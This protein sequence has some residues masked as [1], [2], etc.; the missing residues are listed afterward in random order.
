MHAKINYLCY[1]IIMNTHEL[2]YYIKNYIEN[3]KTQRAIMLT[4]PWGCGK[5]YYIKNN[6]CPFLIEN[7]LNYVVTS[8]YGIKST[9]DISRNIYLE[10]RSK[11]LIAKS[12][13]TNLL[14]ITGKTILKGITSFFGIDLS[15][16]EEDLQ[17]LY[18]S[19]NLSNYLLIFEDL[20]RS[21]IDITEVLGYVNNL[22]EQDGVKVL[23]VANEKEILKYRE[24]QESGSNKKI[25]IETEE[26][27][28]YLRIKE[29]TICD[30][31]QFYSDSYSSIKSILE[32]F[33]NKYFKK[34]LE[35]KDD[36]GDLSLVRRINQQLSDVDCFNFRSLLYA[37]QKMADMLMKLDEEEYDLEFLENLFIGTIIYSIK[38][39]NGNKEVWNES[40]YTSPNLGSY[41]YP[42]YKVMYDFIQKHIFNIGELKFAQSLFLKAKDTSLADEKLRVIYNYYIMPEKIVI[43]AID[44]IYDRLKRDEG[45]IHNEYVKLA[46]YLIAI[47]DTLSYDKI[48]KLL[49]QMLINIK[50]AICVGEDIQVYSLSGI[51]LLSKK[52]ISMFDKFKTDMN[53]IISQKQSEWELFEYNPNKLSD[54]Y[55]DIVKN[56]RSFI[57]EKGF[58]N[59]LDTNKIIEMMKKCSAEQIYYFRG[60]LS[61]VYSGISNVGEIFNNDIENLSKIKK[62]IELIITK[63]LD[64][65][66]IQKLQ[67]SWLD[68]DLKN[69]IKNLNNNDF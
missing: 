5:S 24:K 21:G 35:N 12:E 39:N 61:Y 62:G 56:K 51:Q 42:L 1:N 66:L 30:T 19:I 69:I 18:E 41:A 63:S 7:K 52:S 16:S 22:V 67:L 4:A 31:I 28:N 6:L 17:K 34:M 10:I 2:N 27:K 15:H 53:D 58:A 9:N 44:D 33:D 45:I 49:E 11:K 48:K 37:C 55:N 13:T 40:S 65:D 68:N 50:K 25:H 8:L 38:L 32:K 43:E 23:I 14:K 59:K 3:D 26:T 47:Y 36:N 29:K 64:Q 20:E 57:N 54:Y 46:N 60:I